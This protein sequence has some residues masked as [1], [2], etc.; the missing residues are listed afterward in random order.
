MSAK[1]QEKRIRF[2]TTHY[3]LLCSALVL[4]VGSVFYY[5][6][7]ITFKKR[8]SYDALINDYQTSLLNLYPSGETHS[9]GLGNAFMFN[10]QGFA[11]TCAHV[12]KGM[13]NAEK[14]NEGSRPKR[15]MSRQ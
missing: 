15:P 5:S 9:P 1:R 4:I 2:R 12:A 10:Q 11:L 7:F 6:A 8:E 3:I 14:M 13:M